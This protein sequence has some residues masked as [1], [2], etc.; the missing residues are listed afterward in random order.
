MAPICLSGE[1]YLPVVR[2]ELLI[3]SPISRPALVRVDSG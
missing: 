3:C 1:V 2:A